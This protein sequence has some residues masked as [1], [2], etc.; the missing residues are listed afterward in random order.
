MPLLSAALIVRDEERTLPD[1]LES[2]KGVVDEIVVVDTGSFDRTRD[3]ARAA[4]ARLHEF[5]WRDDFSAARNEAIGRCRGEW[6]LYIDADER[7][8][9]GS[10]GDLESALRDQEAV[11]QQVRFHVRPS[12]TPYWE[13]RLF[14]NHPALRFTGIIHE[15]IWPAVLRLI[16]DYGGR[17]GRTSLTIDH[18]GYEQE[19]ERKHRRNLRLLVRALE[20][21]PTAVF[22]W[23]ELGRI[24]YELGDIV[25]AREALSRGIEVVRANSSLVPQDSLPFVALAVIALRTGDPAPEPLLA[26]ALELFPEQPHLIWLEGRRLLDERQFDAAA[27]RFC[28]LAAHGN[29][30]LIDPALAHDRRLFGA[31]P[32]AG[33]AT[34]R[35]A[36]GDY[37]E[38]ADL[39]AAASAGDPE[40]LEF[41]VK[42][43]LA[44][45]LMGA[46]A[47][48]ETSCP[49][50]SDS[51]QVRTSAS[52]GSPSS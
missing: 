45:R 13:L 10:G 14:R 5:A 3:V 6:I 1:C 44:A 15:N 29:H 28:V 39:F 19:Q 32:L 34:C 38:A 18:F 35:F 50:R 21:D 52:G 25:A 4:G 11:G 9:P 49:A 47:G 7:V 33:L 36:E 37:A 24:R 31:W 48:Q 41:R 42:H 40:A 51:R 2:L 23:Y 26:E 43:A 8:R 16:S 20:A 17:V 12:L 27:R 46:A 22:C 30:E